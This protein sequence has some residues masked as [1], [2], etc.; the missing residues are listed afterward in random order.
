MSPTLHFAARRLR[1]VFILAF[2]SAG[3]V[4]AVVKNVPGADFRAG[5]GDFLWWAVLLPMA[6]GWLF[7]SMLHEAFHCPTSLLLP[8][9]LAAF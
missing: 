8:A 5:A 6:W 4:A 2:F 1:R 3:L 9:P 7:S